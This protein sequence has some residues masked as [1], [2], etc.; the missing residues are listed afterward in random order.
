[1]RKVERRT[2]TRRDDWS[3]GST[4]TVP[5]PDTSQSVYRR[6]P[7]VLVQP[8]FN[9]L[10][11]VAVCCCVLPCGAVCCCELAQAHSSCVVHRRALC[12][13]R[14]NF[15]NRHCTVRATDTRVMILTALTTPRITDQRLVC[16]R[17]LAPPTP[18]LAVLTLQFGRAIP[19]KRTPDSEINNSPSCS[20]YSNTQQHDDHRQ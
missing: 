8:K 11:C 10:L 7:P 2:K 5:Y 16:Q 6:N 15:V 13:C 14:S 3:L 20:N 4:N 9:R 17:A 19:W 1:V 12:C 18:V